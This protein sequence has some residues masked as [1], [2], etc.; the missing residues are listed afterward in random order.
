MLTISKTKREIRICYYKELK[1]MN[2][3][4]HQLNKRRATIEELNL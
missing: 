1:K 3:Q 2:L 4:I